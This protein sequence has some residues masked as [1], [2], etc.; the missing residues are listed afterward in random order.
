[1]LFSTQ[2]RS[3]FIHH[4]SYWKFTLTPSH[5]PITFL[6][7]QNGA[8]NH[9]NLKT[10]T[11][12]GETDFETVVSW[13]IDWLIDVQHWRPW[14]HG[15]RTCFIVIFL[16]VFHRTMQ[17][18]H[19]DK[20]V[21]LLDSPGVVFTKEGDDVLA[22]LRNTIKVYIF[23]TNL[24]FR[25]VSFLWS[26]IIQYHVVG[27]CYSG[28]QCS[29]LR[30]FS[31]NARRSN[32]WSTTN[33]RISKTAINF[34]RSSPSKGVYWRREECRM[35]S[36]LHGSFFKTGLGKEALTLSFRFCGF[37]NT[38]IV[39]SYVHFC[40]FLIHFR[41]VLSI[42]TEDRFDFSIHS[43][44]VP[45]LIDLFHIFLEIVFHVPFK[46]MAKTDFISPFIFF[47]SWIFFTRFFGNFLMNISF[48]STCLECQFLLFHWFLRWIYGI[49][50]SLIF[51]SI[52][53]IFSIFLN[54]LNLIFFPIFSVWFF[55]PSWAFFVP[56]S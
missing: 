6:I 29:R 10:S 42:Y 25:F 5:G 48:C 1:M 15:L 31:R 47:C 55:I 14:W 39:N 12:Q 37:S 2:F 19:L 9:Q 44:L 13:L 52:F 17:E 27:G 32:W 41:I 28:I 35:S 3:V 7:I 51:S 4:C 26:R 43:R 30:R 56:F 20:H 36:K 22:A 11:I 54:F 8:E 46:L 34:W 21:T 24:F 49:F 23:K 45:W 33:C 50:F 40:P 53:G 18:I 38:Q 16:F